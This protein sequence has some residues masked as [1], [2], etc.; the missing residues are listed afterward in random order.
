M[1]MYNVFL[2]GG[3]TYTYKGRTRPRGQS[4]QVDENEAK[5]WR[6]LGPDQAQVSE[7]RTTP[8][9]TPPPVQPVGTLPITQIPPPAPP[10]P[11]APSA[12]LSGTPV[13]GEML[14]GVESEFDIGPEGA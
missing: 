10:A 14:P 6:G 7:F 12:P 8:P 13:D 3:G 9:P 5:Y 4:F 1:T 2:P 11:P